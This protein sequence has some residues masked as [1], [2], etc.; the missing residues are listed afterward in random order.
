MG[1][2]ILQVDQG[3]SSRHF[4]IYV[5]VCKDDDFLSDPHVQAFSGE[6]KA[7][8]CTFTRNRR[9]SLSAAPA[10]TLLVAGRQVETGMVVT[11]MGHI[12]RE[13]GRP[14]GSFGQ[15]SEPRQTQEGGC[16]TAS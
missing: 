16:L 4:S 15:G 9:A 6:Q 10:I 12:R 13:S 1:T 7:R 3:A 8:R 11:C 14:A 5:T 2:D